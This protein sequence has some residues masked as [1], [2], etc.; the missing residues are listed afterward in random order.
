MQLWREFPTTVWPM[1]RV[2]SSWS[3]YVQLLQFSEM[4]LLIGGASNLHAQ[5]SDTCNNW[6]ECYR[7]PWITCISS[8]HLVGSL[9][10]AQCLNL[11]GQNS[12]LSY[13]C[14]THIYWW[15]IQSA[16]PAV[17]KYTVASLHLP[18]AWRLRWCKTELWTFHMIHSSGQPNQVL[19]QNKYDTTDHILEDQCFL[20]V[21]HRAS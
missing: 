10:C 12:L 16:C 20:G 4:T 1:F 9:Q 3:L 21:P 15:C 14:H 5:L 7:R 19:P 17:R 2:L 11:V 13:L 6:I 18:C 8:Y